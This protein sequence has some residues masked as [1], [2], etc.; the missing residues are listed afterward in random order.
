MCLKLKAIFFILDIS[1][2]PS[3][4][5][6]LKNIRLFCIIIFIK[7]FQIFTDN[8]NNQYYQNWNIFKCVI[9]KKKANVGI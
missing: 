9:T 5:K 8:N 3:S 1:A 4:I 2:A 7:F 6:L